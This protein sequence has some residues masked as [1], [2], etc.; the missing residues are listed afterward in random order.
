MSELLTLNITQILEG[1]RK[2]QFSAVEVTQAYLDRIEVAYKSLQ[3]NGHNEWVNLKSIHYVELEA[4]DSFY[5][6]L[7]I[8]SDG[9]HI[10][11]NQDNFSYN[12]GTDNYKNINGSEGNGDVQ[13]YVYPDTEDLDG[14][15][16]QDFNND[17]F[18]YS[19]LMSIAIKDSLEHIGM[20]DIFFKSLISSLAYV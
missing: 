10:D 16:L 19:M 20:K 7:D 18:T 12:E 4:E 13:G 15:Y 11:P 2:K 8:D 3:K 5:V 17:Y 9:S 6:Y 14:D 1:L